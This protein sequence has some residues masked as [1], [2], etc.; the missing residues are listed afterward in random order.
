MEH[1]NQLLD[2]PLQTAHEIKP[3]V[4]SMEKLVALLWVRMGDLFGDKWRVKSGDIAD[5]DGNYTQTFMLWC[6]KLDG[7]TQ[8]QFTHGF[9]ELETRAAN[10]AKDGKE[11]WPPSYAEFI[12]MASQNWETAAHKPFEKLAL[13]DKAAQERTRQAGAETLKAMKS[14]FGGKA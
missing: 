9:K 7:L 6:R 4:S 12:G 14:L 13:P 10:A 5:K 11:C 8:K 1:I 2:K 3:C